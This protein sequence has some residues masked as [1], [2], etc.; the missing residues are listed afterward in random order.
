MNK[1]INPDIKSIDITHEQF[2]RMQDLA[3]N[4]NQSLESV[5]FF[6]IEHGLV[7][8]EKS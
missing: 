3:D 4:H 7:A 1:F 6:V 8:L 5:I 2:Q